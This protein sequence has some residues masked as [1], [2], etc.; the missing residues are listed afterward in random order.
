MA[1]ANQVYSLNIGLIE[2]G[3]DY[4]LIPSTVRMRGTVRCGDLPTRADLGKRL[5]ALV[6]PA[7]ESADCTV[8]FKFTPGNPP[9][10]NEP[11][12][13][14][15]V[16]ETAAS[17]L[18]AENAVIMDAPLLIGDTFCF[19]AEGIPSVYWLFGSGNA[20]RGITHP[21]HHSLYDLDEA[22]IGHALQVAVEASL[23][24]LSNS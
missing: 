13:T 23:A 3:K 7:A 8:D 1:P 22:S 20:E 21:L 18:G 15:L 2:G 17:V 4:N 10:V 14:S 9:V 6:H 24:Y 5:E 19:L 11:A 16:H 12:L